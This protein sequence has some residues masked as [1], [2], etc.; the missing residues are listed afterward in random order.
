M[1]KKDTVIFRNIKCRIS[2]LKLWHDGNEFKYSAELVD[3]SNK[4][5]IYIAKIGEVYGADTE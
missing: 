2:F 5:H 1:A 4:N 3:M